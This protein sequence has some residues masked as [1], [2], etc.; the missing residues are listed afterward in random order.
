MRSRINLST[1]FIKISTLSYF[2][3]IHLLMDLNIVTELGSYVASVFA[4]SGILNYSTCSI[5]ISLLYCVF[6]TILTI[7]PLLIVLQRLILF[8]LALN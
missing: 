6:I 7:L 4:I 3:I 1:S 8:H 5:L 2:L